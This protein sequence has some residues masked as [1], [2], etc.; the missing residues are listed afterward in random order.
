MLNPLNLMR[1]KISLSPNRGVALVW[2]LL[3]VAIA[4]WL[5]V[6]MSA[7]PTINAN[8]VSML[9]TVDRDPVVQDAAEKFRE[10][11]E[12]RVVLLVGA[13]N[14]TIAKAAADTV[15]EALQASR[16]FAEL[17]TQDDTDLIERAATFYFPLRFEL[18]SDAT[19][20]QLM[21]GDVD[22]I[23]RAVLAQYFNPIS[24]LQSDLI[25]QDPLHLLSGFLAERAAANSGRFEMEEGFVLIRGDAQTYVLL[26]GILNESPFSFD[27]QNRLKPVL[28]NLTAPTS[29]HMA[30]V[31]ILK[32]GV[33]FHAAAGTANAKINLTAYKGRPLQRKLPQEFLQ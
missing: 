18:L 28:E 27:L 7:E 8:L 10:R 15:L 29:A 21:A 14:S 6:R 2:V 16:N 3:L 12:R 26:T 20:Q 24:G 33:F 1:L 25:E 30:G 5:A 23:E 31:T 32:A 19:R 17:S 9:P 13:P 11:F 4:A 22:K